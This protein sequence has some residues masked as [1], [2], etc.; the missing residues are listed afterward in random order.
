MT[1]TLSIETAAGQSFQHGFHLGTIE[2]VA[3]QIA[4]EMFHNRVK[5][6]HPVVTVALIRGGK[7]FDCYD[8]KWHSEYKAA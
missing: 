8:G 3:R 1:F 5:Y 6:G 7:L 4:E 2:S